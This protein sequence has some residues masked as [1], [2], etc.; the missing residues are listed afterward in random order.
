MALA[1]AARRWVTPPP[2][3]RWLLTG[4]T[5]APDHA[6]SPLAPAAAYLRAQPAPHLTG[7]FT[8]STGPT[9][10]AIPGRPQRYW[11]M[12]LPCTR[13]ARHPSGTYMAPSHPQRYQTTASWWSGL[14]E[15]TPHSLS[16]DAIPQVGGSHRSALASN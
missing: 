15:T 12:R 10:T 13:M 1:S 2:P 5:S 6:A 3:M 16:G 11:I 14:S 4:P 9:T 7:S 8:W